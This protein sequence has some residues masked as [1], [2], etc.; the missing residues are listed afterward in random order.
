MTIREMAKIIGVSPATVSLV[1]NNKPGLSEATRVSVYKALQNLGVQLKASSLHPQKSIMFVVYRKHGIEK[2][3]TPFFS[4]VY[5]QIIEGVEWQARLLGFSMKVFYL[6]EHTFESQKDVVRHVECEGVLLLATELDAL[7]IFELSI[8]KPMVL[9][10]NYVEECSYASVVFNNTS[11]VKQAVE[12]LYQN[13]HRRIGYLHINHNANNFSDRYYGF[14]RALDAFGLS[15]N[16]HDLCEVST[17]EGGDAVSEIL[18]SYFKMHESLPT[19][20]F[21][22][23][24]IIATCAL[25]VCKQLHIDIPGTVSIIGFDNVGLAEMVDPQL[26]TIDTPK[27]ELGRTAVNV[28]AETMQN[29]NAANKVS[30]MVALKPSLVIRASTSRNL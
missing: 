16:D 10:D 11:G 5:S 7:Q 14:L 2:R 19:S 27:Y 1:L 15:L 22:D 12:F 18:Y 24:D 26:T 30:K 6:D 21:A 29:T 3:H 28:L 25:K 9:L 17:T 23:N 4:Q 20:F 8:N 13:G